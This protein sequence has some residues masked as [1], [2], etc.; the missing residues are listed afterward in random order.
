MNNPAADCDSAALRGRA[1]R[2][3]LHAQIERKI[4]GCGASAFFAWK[5]WRYRLRWPW[6]G[7]LRAV[8]HVT[9]PCDDLARAEAFYV[10]LLGAQIVLRISRTLLMRMGWSAEE[11]ERNQAAHLSLTLGAGPRLDLF[12]YPA[13]R[14]SEPALHPHIAFAVAPRDF[15]SW[16]ER[17]T[18]QGVIVAGPTQAGP[19]GQASFYFNDPFGNHLEIVTTGFTAQELPVGM[20]D[21]SRLDYAWARSPR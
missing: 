4:I 17:L 6:R 2:L 1:A 14:Q 9:F 19:R 16:K 15:L 8:D 10:G 18:A 11:I 21:R 20:P 3:P 7:K 12:E 5:R 13:G